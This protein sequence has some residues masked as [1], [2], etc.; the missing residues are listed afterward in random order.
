MGIRFFCPKGHKLNV[1][2]ELAGKIG[3]CPK[4]GEK[5]MIPL[6]STRDPGE[7]KSSDQENRAVKSLDVVGNPGP[8]GFTMEATDLGGSAVDNELSNLQSHYLVESPLGDDHFENEEKSVGVVQVSSDTDS[9]QQIP[10]TSSA[11]DHVSPDPVIPTPEQAPSNQLLSDPLVHWYVRSGDNQSYGPA[12]GAI[13]QSWI[14][15]RRIGPSML[16]WREGWS[17]WLEARNVFPELE[18]VFH[19]TAP[20]P[21]R[22]SPE[23]AEKS[24]LP[25]AAE[26]DEPSQTITEQKK[27][28][29]KKKAHRDLMIVISLIVVIIV[30][31]TLLCFILFKQK[32]PENP[33]RPAVSSTLLS[34]DYPLERDR[35]L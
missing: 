27:I 13:I 2:A 26:T 20:E 29:R 22:I 35:I 8:E 6:V 9:E 21:P 30:L 23:S 16:V 14:K 15:E 10:Q 19:S 7:K 18:A 31:I 25:T 4:C 11:K 33:S 34:P 28:A 12:S 1:K 5:M 32:N 3:I 17:T 24:L